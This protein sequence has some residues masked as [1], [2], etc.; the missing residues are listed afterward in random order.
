MKNWITWTQ[1]VK[2]YLNFK[3]LEKLYNKQQKE[4]ILDLARD[5]YNKWKISQFHL[6]EVYF[7]NFIK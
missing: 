5:L 1:A 4:K 7:K 6:W 2:Q 3:R